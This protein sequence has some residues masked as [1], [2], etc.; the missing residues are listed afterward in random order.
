MNILKLF[1]PC[2]FLFLVLCISNVLLQSYDYEYDSKKFLDGINEEEN[3]ENVDEESTNISPG[4]K[5]TGNLL[6]IKSPAD[7]YVDYVPKNLPEKLNLT[8]LRLKAYA[9]HKNKKIIEAK[10][11]SKYNQLKWMTYG[12]IR[13]VQ[14]KKTPNSHST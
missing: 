3:Y 6:E 7:I 10:D 4:I 2:L 9:L 5:V 14:I 1:I 8:K 12:Y 11:V 13:L